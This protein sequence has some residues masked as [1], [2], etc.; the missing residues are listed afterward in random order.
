MIT[1]VTGKNQVTLP[2]KLA[3]ALD[4]KPGTKLDWQLGEDGEL[5]VRPVLSRAQLARKLAGIGR[6]WLK[7]GDDPI[8]DLIRER[9]EDDC[10]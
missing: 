1:T 2:A 9:V 7:P 10:L 6:E 4:I 5:I 3:R 8:G